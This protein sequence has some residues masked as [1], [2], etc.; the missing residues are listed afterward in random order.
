MP[1]FGQHRNSKINSSIQFWNIWIFAIFGV[2]WAHAGGQFPDEMEPSRQAMDAGVCVGYVWPLEFS[3]P[4]ASVQTGRWFSWV[5]V[6]PAAASTEFG[7]PENPT[8]KK[9]FLS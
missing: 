5:S 4:R 3:F 6:N 7:H 9:A 8:R 2:F 1:S